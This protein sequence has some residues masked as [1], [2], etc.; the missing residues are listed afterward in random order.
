MSANRFK[1]GDIVQF[2][3]SNAH[4]GIVEGVGKGT[5]PIEEWRAVAG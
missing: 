2:G 1:I 3:N 5:T 4:M